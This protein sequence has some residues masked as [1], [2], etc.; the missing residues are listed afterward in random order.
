MRE[1]TAMREGVRRARGTDVYMMKLSVDGQVTWETTGRKTF[2][3]AVQVRRA[4]LEELKRGESV[5][6]DDR[7]QLLLPVGANY[8]CRLVPS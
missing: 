7:R 8:F 3:E 2:A 4:K 6:H 1:Q 5:P